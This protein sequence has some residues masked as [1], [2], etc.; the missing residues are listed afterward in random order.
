MDRRLILGEVEIGERREGRHFYQTKLGFAKIQL[1][2]KEREQ[3]AT[4]CALDKN[5]QLRKDAITELGAKEWEVIRK[6]EELEEKQRL[7]QTKL[8]TK[9]KNILNQTQIIEEKVWEYEETQ[10]ALMETE[11]KR[12]RPRSPRRRRYFWR[13]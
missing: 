8:I 12:R 13:T 10:V 11:I 9:A 2:E 5:K 4:I 1:E 3:E 7:H 6:A